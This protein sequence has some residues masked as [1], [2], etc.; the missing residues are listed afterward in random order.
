MAAP[1]AP[2]SRKPRPREPA[3]EPA[4]MMARLIGI[5]GS[6]HGVRFSAR[7]PTKTSSR[8]ASGPRP[9]NRPFSRTPFS[10]LWM[11]CR[12]SLVPRYPPVVPRIVKLS[13]RATPSSE[14]PLAA[15]VAEPEAEAQ[16]DFTGALP[17]PN[18]IAPNTS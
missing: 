16:T 11:N 10:A 14:S 3:C 5:I 2:P 8:I 17:R 15:A 9:S 6:T 18:A 7:P 12:K 13:R 4:P 1:Y